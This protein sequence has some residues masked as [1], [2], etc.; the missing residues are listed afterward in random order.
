VPVPV[1][2][3]EPVPLPLDEVNEITVVDVVELCDIVTVVD[4]ILVPFV[5]IL[6]VQVPVTQAVLVAVFVLTIT[7]YH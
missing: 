7:W 5:G 2:V 1:P 4:D 6:V 3:P